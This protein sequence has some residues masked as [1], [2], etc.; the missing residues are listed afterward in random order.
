MHEN[1]RVLLESRVIV[2][3]SLRSMS[4]VMSSFCFSG[5]PNC[6]WIPLLTIDNSLSFIGFGASAFKCIILTIF[7]YLDM[8]DGVRDRAKNT[9][10][11]TIV[12]LEVGTGVLPK[13]RQNLGKAFHIVV[14]A[15]L[16]DFTYMQI[17]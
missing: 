4:L 3:L 16:V 7:M 13:Y 6:C 2:A 9:R 14:Y 15:V 17:S 12:S 1:A 8:L 11:I 5:P 10:Y